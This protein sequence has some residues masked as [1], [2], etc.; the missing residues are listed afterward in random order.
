MLV[1][2]V[3][4]SS[5]DSD[6]PQGDPSRLVNVYRESAG[7]GTA[8]LK[9][10][11]GMEPLTT[12]PGTFV[13]AM[14]NVDGALYAICAGRLY[15]IGSD[16]S[17]DDLGAVE[18]GTALIA[19]NNGH[20]TVAAGGR[21]FVHDGAV[22]TEPSAGAF[23]DFGSV[24]YFGN[25]TV[26]T[27]RGGRRFQWSALADPTDLPGLNFSTA[28]GRDDNLVRPM[29]LH[30]QLV[31]FKERSHELW[32]NTGEAGANA[33]LRVMGGVRDVG[34]RSHDLIVR[35]SGA[36]FMVGSDNRAHLIGP[37]GLQP[38]STPPVET[39]I[40]LHGPQ[41]CVTY[42]DEGHTFCA[43][44]FRDAPAWVYDVATGEWH[45][46]ASG[47]DLGP[48]VVSA[49]AM[50]GREWVVGSTGGQVSI[51][52][53]VNSDGAVPLVREATSRTLYLDG[54]RGVLREF[55]V[56]PQRGL[57]ASQMALELSRD[58]GMT[59]TLPKPRPVGPVGEYGRRVIWRG[60]GQ[61]RS[62]NAR[63]RWTDPVDLCLSS[64]ARVVI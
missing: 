58:G 16:G 62:I 2:F 20:V 35:F 17:A 11:L 54:A 47:A 4:Q 8:W 21:Y 39:A 59:W 52:R 33:F 27:E 48:W 14:G 5:K 31:L 25:Y 57:A 43:I 36:A 7:T 45:E 9:S 53:R 22:L 37:A 30:G 6:N 56:F 61:A 34:L 63:I 23:A 64:K 46:R 13:A 38:V 28:D 51:L 41:A 50:L 44:I 15:R 18:T 40:K 10:V 19:G 29:A 32:Y 49:S 60:L 24:D 3:G 42:S 55:E 1:E 26:L 12:L